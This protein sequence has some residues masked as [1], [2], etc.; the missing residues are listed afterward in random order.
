MEP[1]EGTRPWLVGIRPGQ[2]VPLIESDEPVIRV[3]AGP[4]TGKTLG[5]RRRV[6]RLQHRDGLNIDPGRVLVC[7]FN[8][9]IARDLEKEIQEE[10]APH[11]LALPII[12]TV[13][14]LCAEISRSDVRLLLPHE[15]EEMIYDVRMANPGIDAAYDHRQAR[16]VRALREHEAG[17]VEHPGLMTAVRQ[18]LADHGAG[19]VGDVPRRVETAL[20]GGHELSHEYEHVVV[21]EFQ[22]LTTTEARVV[23]SLR[24]NGGKLVAVGD[25]KQS[26][27]AFR[28]NATKGLDALPDLVSDD[29]ADHPIGPMLALSQG[30]R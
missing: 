25:R 24:A 11:G 13:H 30:D 15:I 21:D 9:A 8:R 22:D 5:I 2:V 1:L 14:A 28:G 12:K 17:L 27:Y 18:W 6:L 26:I 7:A 19:L 20:R 4:G 16:A 23:T 3:S 10:L 29:I